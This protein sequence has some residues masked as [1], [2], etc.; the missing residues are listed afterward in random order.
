MKKM[1]ILSPLSDQALAVAGYLRKYDGY[2]VHGGF[3]PGERMRNHKYYEKLFYVQNE[4]S[5]EGYD[6]V[7]PTGARSTHWMI[8]HFGT[9]RVNGVDYS[10]ANL[11]CFRKYTFLSHVK[12]LGVP[13]PQTYEEPEVIDVPYP[14]F[15]KPKFERGGG[16]RGVVWSVRELE[17][18]EHK[19]GLIYQEYI[20]GSRTYGMG[21]IAQ[22]GRTITSFQHEELLSFPILGGSAVYIRVF[23]DERIKAYTERILES[24]E[25]S[26][27]GLAEYKYCPNRK[28][29]VFMEIN[30]KLWASIE[31]TFMNNSDFLWHLC[32]IRYPVE[33][34]KSACYVGRLISLGWPGILKGAPYLLKASRYVRYESVGSLIISAFLMSLPHGSRKWIKEHL[35]AKLKRSEQF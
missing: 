35:L 13:V 7:L 9:F 25:Y 15:Y 5:V 16:P 14:I 22:G 1:L 17:K 18:L 33:D 6:C 29:Y 10:K 23:H 24:M 8:T 20:T 26:G 30:A 27:W 12:N 34:V 2:I 3:M 32:G 4:R 31:F 21:F 19:E 28:D 11:R